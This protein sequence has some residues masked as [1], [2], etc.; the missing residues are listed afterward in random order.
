MKKLL[1][2]PL[3]RFLFLGAAIFA[4]SS[5]MSRG[6]TDKP[7]EIVVTR[8][9]LDALVTGFTR[10]WHRPPTE[11]EML[12]LVRDYVRE[13]A[14][15][16]EAMAQGL[17][18]DDTVI[19]R[20]LRQKLEFL[21][22]D[23]SAKLE[24]SDADLDEYLR[25][26]PQQFR[27]DPTFTFR[28][29]YLNPDKHGSDLDRAA[30]ALLAHLRRAGEAIDLNSAGDPFLLEY[31]FK[32]VS[33][34]EVGQVLG[35]AFAGSLPELPVGQWSGPVKSGY[36]MHLVLVVERNDTQQRPLADVRSD[37]LREWRNAKRQEALDN[38]YAELLRRYA[39]RIEPLPENKLAE[40]R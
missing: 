15:Y 34:G 35:T 33:L 28:H 7:G 38:Y 11:Q 10:T 3:V 39:V 23:L 17:D 29:V 27:A 13:E 9:R 12:G 8:G 32:S 37:V 21:T 26:H 36:G 1:R 25:S 14:A 16:R 18:R 22:E 24:P 30:R 6:R 4:V 31:Q 20:R 19:R 5:F 2:E 40:A